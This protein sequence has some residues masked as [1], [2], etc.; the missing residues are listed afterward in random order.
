MITSSPTITTKCD[1]KIYYIKTEI[2][3]IIYSILILR[4]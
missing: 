1:K 2:K 4:A 3:N